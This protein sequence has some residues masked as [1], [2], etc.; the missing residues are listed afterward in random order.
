MRT[1]NR[2]Y[3]GYVKNSAN[4]TDFTYLKK[5]WYTGSPWRG[6]SSGR[7][8]MAVSLLVQLH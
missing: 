7:E 5:K 2:D 3:E 8:T 1:S 6:R 4:I